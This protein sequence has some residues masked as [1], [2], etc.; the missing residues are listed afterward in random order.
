MRKLILLLSCIL[1][2]SAQAQND[3]WVSTWGTATQLAMDPSLNF[4]RPPPAEKTAE[5]AAPA[6]KPPANPPPSP[7]PPVP[8]ELNDQTVRMVVRSSVAGERVRL[9]FANAQGMAPVHFGAVHVALHGKGAA[10]DAGSDKVVTFG[11]QASVIL[12]PGSLVV[13]DPV[14]LPVAALTELAVSVYLPQVTDARTTH[15]LGLNTTYI[16]KGNNVGA[17]TL[18]D[19]DT[20]RSYFWL[21]GVEVQAAANAGT[22]IAFGDSITDG[23]S[24]TPDQHREWPALL[25]QRLQANSD[26][27]QLGVINM[28]ISGNR[29]LRTVTGVSALARFDRDVL[30]RSGVRWIILLEGINDINFTALPGSPESEHAT[31]EAIIGGLS[32]LVD[33]AHAHGIKV[34]GATLTPMGGLWLFNEKTEAMRQQV[35][36]WIRT[37]GKYDALV[38]FDAAT[39]DPAKPTHMKPAHNS[40]DNIHPNDAGNTAMAEAI[41]LAV[42]NSK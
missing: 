16:T 7:I 9:Q 2:F 24:T 30:A 29:I 4:V 5:N 13:S 25:A 37:S 1:A 19:A 21:T 14:D 10:I 40:G 23:F 39:R 27:A 26:T 33:R 22:I 41:D 28:G 35:N 6:A 20:N 36:Q 3:Q 18:T 42:F 17:S 15:A 34:M 11:G 8:T 12:H 32:Q 38:D 31:A